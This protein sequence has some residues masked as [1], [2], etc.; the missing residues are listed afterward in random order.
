MYSTIMLHTC[1][2]RCMYGVSADVCYHSILRI[3]LVEFWL[4]L[5]LY[6]SYQPN[7]QVSDNFH[8]PTNSHMLPV[9]RY[10][11]EQFRAGLV[12]CAVT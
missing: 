2:L 6:T 12:Q 8:N 3:G 9:L 1:F 11:L 7:I 4:S 5:S 10:P